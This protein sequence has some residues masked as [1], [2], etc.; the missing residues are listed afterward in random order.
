MQPLNSKHWFWPFQSCPA[1]NGW[2]SLTTAKQTD[3]ESAAD[4]VL[5]PTTTAGG[6]SSPG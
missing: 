6:A 4:K 3:A 5:A 1:N 2:H